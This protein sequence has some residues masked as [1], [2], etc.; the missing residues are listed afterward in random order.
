MIKL[1]L[2]AART[3]LWLHRVHGVGLAMGPIQRYFET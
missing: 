3:R 2:G 1:G